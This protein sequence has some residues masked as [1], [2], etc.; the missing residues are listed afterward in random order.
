MSS[1]YRGALSN[2]ALLLLCLCLGFFARRVPALP[3]ESHRVLNAW[4]MYISLPALVFRSIHKA[5]IDVSMMAACACLWLVFAVPAVVSLMLIRRGG[6]REHLGALALC[7]GLGNT[8]FVGLPLIEAL[9]GQNALGPAAVVDQM[10]SFLALFLFAMPFAA[11]LGGKKTTPLQWATKLIR[12]P[13]MV[14]LLA[15]LVLRGQT[16]PVVVGD[17]I[18]RFADMLS[19][20]ALASIGW[21][22]DFSA[23][24]GN[25]RRIAYGLTWKLVFAPA[26]VLGLMLLFRGQFGLLERV[27]VAQAAMAPMV[28]A[29]VVAAENR[30]APALASA[31]IAVGVP[32]SLLTVPLWWQLTSLLS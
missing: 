6:S 29:G 16:M 24:A 31:L 17:V 7:S 15:A 30:L 3:P 23:F 11:W 28:T 1:K 26:M 9:G 5:N 14:A 8:A 12:A 22:L 25:A 13:A 21:Q 4:V 10:G 32:L 20:L 19:P 18:V 2:F 27:V